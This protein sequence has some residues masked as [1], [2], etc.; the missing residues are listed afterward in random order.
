VG[1]AV[2]A[3]R[4]R[5]G[6]PRSS[7]GACRIAVARAQL[8]TPRASVRGL[9]I[10]TRIASRVAHS[11][12]AGTG[13]VHRDSVRGRRNGGRPHPKQR[14]RHNAGPF[15]PISVDGS[16][17]PG[18]TPKSIDEVDW[19]TSS[20]TCRACHRRRRTPSPGPRRRSPRW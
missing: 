12:S 3:I 2:V 14:A 10:R 1:R 16:W 6:T 15:G 20:P 11:L 19:P 18:P 8:H 17:P 7:R 13:F 5:D 4:P 9:W